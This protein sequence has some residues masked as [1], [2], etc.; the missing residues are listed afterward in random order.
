MS[1]DK[2]VRER[3]EL[4]HSGSDARA[5]LAEIDRLEKE[6]AELKFNKNRPVSVTVS[7]SGVPTSITSSREAELQAEIDRLEKELAAFKTANKSVDSGWDHEKDLTLRRR[8]SIGGYAKEDMDAIFSALKEIDRLTE[9][10]RDRHVQLIQKIDEI[11]A[12]K[13]QLAVAK[14]LLAAKPCRRVTTPEEA[15]EVLNAKFYLDCGWIYNEGE[16]MAP[17]ECF[18]GESV[19]MEIATAIHVANHLLADEQ[20]KPVLHRVTTLDLA[21]HILNEKGYNGTRWS[22]ETIPDHRETPYALAAE[23][24]AWNL[25]EAS[26]IIVA[27]HLLSG[28][29]EEVPVAA[30]PSA[31]EDRLLVF[32]ANLI[33]IAKAVNA[34]AR[35]L[36]KEIAHCTGKHEAIEFVTVPRNSI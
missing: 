26:A 19:D 7:G 27:N 15:T 31:I 35:E 30:A 6:I 3:I 1:W 32:E 2:S 10:A 24:E 28:T 9:V 12:L 18:K 21:V 11:A 14:S 29:P 4:F 33:D 25:D 23:P 20:P 13:D 17:V 5:A 16:P 22:L 36:Q 34:N 8:W